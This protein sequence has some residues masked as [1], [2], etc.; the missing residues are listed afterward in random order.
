MDSKG[1][2]GMKD[3]LGKFRTS[4][5][6]RKKTRRKKRTNSSGDDGSTTSSDG[7]N[8]PGGNG[9]LRFTIWFFFIQTSDEEF[10]CKH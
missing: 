7:S 3:R 4:P 5:K 10:E 2:S 8:C 9:H 1:I 6:E